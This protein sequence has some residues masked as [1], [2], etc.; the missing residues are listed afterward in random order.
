M[1]KAQEFR[2]RAQGALRDRGAKIDEAWRRD[3]PATHR[4]IENDDVIAITTKGA[5]LHATDGEALTMAGRL[6][7][8]DW[9]N[10]QFAED[11]DQ[12]DMNLKRERGLIMGIYTAADG[13]DLWVMQSHRFVPP[14]VMLPEER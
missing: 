8:G 12:N 7:A 6:L 11:R 1:G 9:G 2:E 3:L 14:T 5:R 13:A 10:I 4:L